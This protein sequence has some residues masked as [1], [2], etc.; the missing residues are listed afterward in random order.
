[1]FT[2][3]ENTVTFKYGSKSTS[4]N[5]PE[6]IDKM[7]SFAKSCGIGKFNAV[8]NGTNL[9]VDDFNDNLIGKVISIEPINTANV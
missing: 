4:A 9:N 6:A 5:I 1:M 2:T 7:K 3:E 8:C